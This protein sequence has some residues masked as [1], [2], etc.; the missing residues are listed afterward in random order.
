MKLAR[1]GGTF[2]LSVSVGSTCWLWFRAPGP[3]PPRGGGCD[4][5]KGKQGAGEVGVQFVCALRMRTAGLHLLSWVIRPA[6]IILLTQSHAPR[7]S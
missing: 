3:P 5:R 2:A 6:V 7:G 1:D 4:H